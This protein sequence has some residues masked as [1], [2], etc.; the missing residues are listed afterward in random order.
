MRFAFVVL[1][2][3]SLAIPTQAQLRDNRDRQLTCNDS[4]RD[5]KRAH[6]CDVRE[7]TLGPSGKLEIRPGQNGGV[8]VKGWS[9][10]SILVRSRVEAW[11]DRDSDARDVASQIRL[12]ITGGGIAAT[13]PERNGFFN[14]DDDRGWAVSFEIFT[15]WNTDLNVDTHNGGISVNDIRGQMDVGSHNGGLHLTRVAGDIHGQTH[16]GGIQAEVAGNSSDIRGVDLSSHNGAITL[17]M[18]SSFSAR[19]ETQTDHGRL[20][21]DFPVSVS[22]RLDRSNMNFNVGAGGPLV[23]LATHNGGIRL[24]KM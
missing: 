21:S 17:S 22:G 18:L 24:R 11:A 8:T 4:S 12:E 23:R 19:F 14:W 5:G 13:G 9:Q 15:P 2:L 16:N 10:S 3:I 1:T 7:T 20:E 6:V